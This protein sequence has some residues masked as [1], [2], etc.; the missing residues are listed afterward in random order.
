MDNPEG[1]ST[2]RD[3]NKRYLCYFLQLMKNLS[4]QTVTKA[5]STN[6]CF[7]MRALLTDFKKL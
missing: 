2:V 1:I 3:I 7:I 6:V 4:I 5:S